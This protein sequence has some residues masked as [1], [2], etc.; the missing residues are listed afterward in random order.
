MSHLRSNLRHKAALN[1]AA[2]QLSM[3]RA[4]AAGMEADESG[5]GESAYERELREAEERV[6]HWREALTLRAAFAACLVGSIFCIVSLKLGLTSGGERA[7]ACWLGRR[8]RRSCNR[9]DTAWPAW[10]PTAP[11]HAWASAAHPLL[12]R[13]PAVPAHLD[14][15]CG[16]LSYFSIIAGRKLAGKWGRTFKPFTAQVRGRRA[17]DRRR[18][19]RM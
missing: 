10:R 12:P 4:A 14:V 16:L 11:T 13:P 15:G 8:W 18:A 3:A 9:G 17:A 7:P 19:R 6:P 2:R 5:A 1:A